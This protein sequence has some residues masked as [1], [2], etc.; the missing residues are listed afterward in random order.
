[1]STDTYDKGSTGSG[2]VV[3]AAVVMFTIGAIDAIQGLAALFKDD[4][5]LVSDTGLLVA[6]DYTAWGWTLI[7][8]GAV[9]VLAAAALFSG[10]EWGRW[11]AI[12]AIVINMIGQIAWFPAYPLWSLLAIGLGIA[13]LHAL[14]VGWTTARTDLRA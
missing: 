4:V 3:F 13:V 14:T 9:L 1:M 8:W 6:T 10:K 5:F 12:V 11:F 2:W 7:I